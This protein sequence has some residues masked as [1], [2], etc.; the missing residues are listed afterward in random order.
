M[1]IQLLRAAASVFT[2]GNPTLAAGQPAFETDTRKIKV[3]DGSTAWNSLGYLSADAVASWASITGKPSTFAPS[4]H[5]H[6]IADVTGLQ[7]ALDGKQAS[8]S[9]ADTSHTHAI[10]D[11]T[12]LQGALDGKQPVAT[13]LTNTTAA[14]TTAQE[15]KLAGIEDG[16]Q[17]NVATDL[18]YT[19]SSRVLASSTGTDVTLPLF[20]ATEAGLVPLSGGGS[21]NFLRADGSWAA[22]A[23]GGSSDPLDLTASAPAAPAAGTVRMF[24]RSIANRQMPGFIGPSGLDSAVQPFMARNKIG[25]WNPAGGTGGTVPSVFGLSA[26]TTTGMTATARAV[27]ATNMF[28]RTRRLGYVTAATAGAVGHFRQPAG[29]IT[30]GDGGILGGFHYVLRFGISD[31]AA[32]SGARMFMG[33]RESLTPANAEPSTLTNCVGIGHGASDAN[34]R[35]FYGGTAAQTPIDLGAN[36][37]ANTRS[38]DVYELALFSAPASPNVHWEVTRLNTGHVASGTIT[39]SGATILP[40]ATLLITPWGYRTNNAT[41]LAVAVDIVSVYLESDY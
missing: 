36:F 17:A 29:L 40:P 4:E 34:M 19:A 38:V 26:F 21:S 23:G 9:Y 20:T 11:V 18:L 37:P 39:N 5:D 16:A 32:V 41:A 33:L 8:G 6:A 28:T 24:R 15:T 27:A 13:V 25:I 14:F 1:T 35:L 10:A 3:G 7:S 12:G 30:V 31:A 22:P 2:S